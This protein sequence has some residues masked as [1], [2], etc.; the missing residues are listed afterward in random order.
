MKYQ[1]RIK[2]L[3]YYVLLHGEIVLGTF[4]NLKKVADYSKNED[5]Y[6]YWTLTR[7]NESEFPVSKN[8][9]TLFRV[10]HY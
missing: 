9:F 4:G 2:D 8:N 3:Q 10:K 7:K 5:F 1:D 6:S